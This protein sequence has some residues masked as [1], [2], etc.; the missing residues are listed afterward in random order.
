M[1]GPK[2]HPQRLYPHAPPPPP[3]S[4]SDT[5]LGL[6]E[7]A[8]SGGN[9]QS[10]AKVGAAR[11]QGPCLVVGPARR[12]ALMSGAFANATSCVRV[13]PVA[14]SCCVC[15]LLCCPP[16]TAA[17]CRRIPSHPFTH[18]PACRPSSLAPSF[19]PSPSTP[20][21]SCLGCL[22]RS[23]PPCRRPPCEQLPAGQQRR[24]QRARQHA[25]PAGRIVRLP[26]SAR[27]RL[28]R[29]NAVSRTAA[30]HGRQHGGH[31]CRQEWAS[32]SLRQACQPCSLC[33]TIDHNKGVATLGRGFC[34]EGRSTRCK[35]KRDVTRDK[36]TQVDSRGDS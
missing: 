11:G 15:V 4:C 10:R 8:P 5:Y 13:P 36:V 6:W 9:Q 3:S 32:L 18:A 28:Q 14:A 23:P 17:T 24:Q 33:C 34:A 22:T 1:H 7:T 12:Q 26:R 27:G 29:R 35:S 2:A 20:S 31:A 25:A 16:R 30:A 21:P 19:P